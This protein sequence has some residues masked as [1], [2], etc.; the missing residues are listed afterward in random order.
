MGT[1][2]VPVRTPPAHKWGWLNSIKLCKTNLRKKQKFWESCR[3]S[4]SR[5]HN[6]ITQAENVGSH[7]WGNLKEYMGL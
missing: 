3:L 5:I 2:A 6:G 7:K 1:S 4:N